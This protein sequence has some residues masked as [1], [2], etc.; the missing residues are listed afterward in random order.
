MKNL[1][2]VLLFSTILL[3]CNQKKETIKNLEKDPFMLKDTLTQK[4]QSAFDKGTIVGFSAAVVDDSE[5][6]YNRGFG[7]IDIEQKKGYTSNTTQNIASIS[8]TLIGIALMKAQELGKLTIDDPINDYLPF[9]IHNPNHSK[10][11]I[12]I[13]HLA[14]H[15]SSIRD[16]DEIYSKS[17]VLE[18]SEHDDNEG[19]YDWFSKPEARISLIDFI[20]NSL[21]ESGKW[22]KKE[23]FSTTEPGKARE[24]SNIASALCALV[25]EFATEQNYQ[26]FTKEYILNP[27]KMTSS[28]WSS[29][30]IDSTNRSRLFAHKELMIAKY[31]LITYADGGFITSCNDLSLFLSEL[32]KGYK[33]TG[34][35]LSQDGY[36]KLFEKHKFSNMETEEGFGIFIEYTNEF[37]KIK[38]EVI[39]HNGSDPGVVTAMYF[40]PKTETGKIVLVNTD[41]DFDDNFWPEVQS[42]WNSLIAF[43]T[44]LNSYKANQ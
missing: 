36:E 25:I 14:Y 2:L 18:K 35:L 22:Y 11:P 9:E 30:D 17:Y 8:K 16:L 29:E 12:L 7:Y 28:G 10:K 20:K 37:I 19:V 41:S 13:K 34:T 27:L 3:G 21:T 32:M 33:G 39:G 6:I 44:E 43:E 42:I 26:S 1:L 5:L 23:V 24:Y 31:D 40:N 15:T 4:L 38:D